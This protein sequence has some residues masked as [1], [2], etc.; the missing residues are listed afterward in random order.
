MATSNNERPTNATVGAMERGP[1]KRNIYPI[2]PEKPISIWNKDATIIAPCICK[3]EHIQIYY[4]SSNLK[5]FLSLNTVLLFL[6]EF[7]YFKTFSNL[8]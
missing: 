1:I 5:F 3:I 7:N 4:I 2:N 6:T 8:D